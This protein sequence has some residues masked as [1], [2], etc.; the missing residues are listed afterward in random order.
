MK[1]IA[2]LTDQHFPYEDRRAWI[3]ALRIAAK[4]KPDM[5]PICSDDRDF[6][7]ISTFEKDPAQLKNQQTELDYWFKRMEEM[8]DMLEPEWKEKRAA[9]TIEYRPVIG[10]HNQRWLKYLWSHPEV[11]GLNALD[12]SKLHDFDRFNFKWNGDAKDWHLN[13]EWNVAKGLTITHGNRMGIQSQM[14]SRMFDQSVIMGHIHRYN[15][16]THTFPNRDTVTGIQS[17]CLCNLEPRWIV[18]P[19]WQQGL[20]LITAHDDG[21]IEYNP[22]KFEHRDGDVFAYYQGERMCEHSKAYGY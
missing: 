13:Y 19:N 4:F 7:S 14:Q 21:Y 6:Y 15:Q 12:Y 2:F 22:I 5:V 20:L 1:K 3:L 16:I 11:C 9:N 8:K 17:Y 10:N 18:H